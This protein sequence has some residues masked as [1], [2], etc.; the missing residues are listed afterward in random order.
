MQTSL[1]FLASGIHKLSPDHEAEWFRAKKRGHHVQD[2]TDQPPALHQPVRP[3]DGF[4]RPSADRQ[5]PHCHPQRRSPPF[6]PLSPEIQDIRASARSG[7]QR[8]FDD[9][10]DGPG[11]RG[12]FSFC[13][14]RSGFNCHLRQIGQDAARKHYTVASWHIAY[15]DAFQ[16]VRLNKSACR[17]GG[18]AVQKDSQGDGANGANDFARRFPLSTAQLSAFHSSSHH[19]PKGADAAPEGPSYNSSLQSLHGWNRCGVAVLSARTR[20][21]ESPSR[22]QTGVT[23]IGWE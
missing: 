10:S 22:Q 6:R 8:F 4:D 9:S 17:E 16:S 19:W 21:G 2:C 1:L 3:A 12:H 5:Q 14:Q 7:E 15:K 23:I 20:T 11:F 13:N 18:R